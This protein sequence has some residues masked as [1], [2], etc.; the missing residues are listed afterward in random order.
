MT[1]EQAD[2]RAIELVA[3]AIYRSS[4]DPRSWDDTTDLKHIYRDDARR[5]LGGRVSP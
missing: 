1:V 4:G 3:M 5:F 2:Q